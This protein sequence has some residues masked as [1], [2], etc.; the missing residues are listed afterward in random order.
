MNI[1]DAIKKI[2]P[3]ELIR[4]YRSTTKLVKTPSF[5][6]TTLDYDQYWRER[7]NFDMQPRFPIIERFI[8]ADSTVLDI[9]C[10]DGAMLA[11]LKKQK[12]I[13]A[14]GI[15]IS[16]V[17]INRAVSRGVNA[18]VEMLSDLAGKGNL[19]FDHVVMSEVI[20]HVP[21]SEQFV[22]WA[23]SLTN[24]SFIITFPNIAYLP[25]RLRLMLGRFPV[26]WVKHPGEHLRFWSIPDF[27]FWLS[28]IDLPNRS[29][30]LTFV[31][32][33]GITVLGL[34]SL[35]PN[36]FGNQIVVVLSRESSL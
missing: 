26:Q 8:G 32:S 28:H 11:Y 2:L 23:W 10:G 19:Q 4:T 5:S 16:Q 27:K 9:G 20:E 14:L 22:Q 21:N 30:S 31:P 15:D 24:K 13:E 36:L 7:P 34:H 25:H 29:S 1:K 33:N 3:T 6:M 18:R 12:N 17:A 35:L